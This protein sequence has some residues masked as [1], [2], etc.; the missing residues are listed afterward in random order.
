MNKSRILVVDDEPSVVYTYVEILTTHGYDVQAASNGPEALGL[1]EREPFDLLLLDINMPGMDGLSVLRR[2]K[3]T[4]RDVEVIIVTAHG[5][6]ETAAE[7]MRL[8]ALDFVTKPVDIHVLADKVQQ[9]LKR[10]CRPENIVRGNLR[11][12][13]LT[14]IISIN[15]NEGALAALEIQR[16]GQRATLF[17][18]RGEVVHATMG[19]MTGAEVVYQTLAWEEGDFSL[20]VG[21][22]APERTIH[23][24]WSGLLLE[25]LRRIDEAAFDQEQ[26]A[27]EPKLETKNEALV[28]PEEFEETA[29]V[30][31]KRDA[32]AP[33][34]GKRNLSFDWDADTQAQMDERLA[35]LHKDLAP[36]CILLTNRNG[37][38]LNLQGE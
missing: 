29:P 28:W 5:T 20:T 33:I 31:Q 35:Q 10:V 34:K 23:T 36:R 11:S 24:G 27:T 15:C 19:Q 21:Q 16:A 12:M 17:F 6:L 18:E 4:H 25:G 8:G 1:L 9:A 38:V 13:S 30:P 22:S 2:A 32:F 3:D 7:A 37:R 14:S 26:L